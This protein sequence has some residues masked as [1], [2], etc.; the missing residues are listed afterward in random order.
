[1]MRIFESLTG[2]NFP[3]SKYDQTVVADFQFG[4]MENITA[5]THA[6][7][8]IF[9]VDYMPDD[10]EDLVSHELAHSWFGNLV[11]CR[12]WAELWL[13]EGF[14]TFM[15]AA[16]REKAYGRTQYLSKI[17]EDAS[18][19]IAEEAVNR[20][21]HGLFNQEA[22]PNDELFDTTTYQKGGAVVH[23]LREEIGDEAFWKAINVYLNRYKFGNVETPD[24]QKATETAS[25][26]DLDWF[27]KQWVYQAGYPQLE[28]TR[29]Y[30]PQKKILTLTVTQTQKSDEITPEAFVLPLE[31]KISTAGGTKTEKIRIDKRKQEFSFQLDDQPTFISFDENLKIPLKSI[32]VSP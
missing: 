24:L 23:T 12:N 14:A 2:V 13:N 22:R 30:E 1:M 7:T 21:P 10:T 11:T 25:G 15:E 16:Y 18:R 28:I 8:E 5:T 3:Y 26:R 17:K 9:A 6:D 27:F 4:G 20:N 19:Y 29:L 31:V 32:K